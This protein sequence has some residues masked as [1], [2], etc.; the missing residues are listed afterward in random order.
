MLIFLDLDG[1][2]VPMAGWKLPKNM[3]DGFPMFS[4]KATDALQRLISS[5]TNVILSTSHRDKFTI[6]EWKEIFNRRGLKIEKLSC[7]ESNKNFEKKRKDEILGWFSSHQVNDRFI[8][9]DDDKTLNG[10]P[11]HLKQH[12]ILT[13]PLV[14]LTSEHLAQVQTRI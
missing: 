4:K 3:D 5:D 12:L 8:I 9:I 1:V 6:S 10:L 2:M 14:G 7:L 13:S 11:E